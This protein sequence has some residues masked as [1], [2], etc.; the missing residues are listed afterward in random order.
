MKK[1]LLLIIIG[2]LAFEAKRIYDKPLQLHPY[3]YEFTQN[4]PIELESSP[5]ILIV[6]DRMGEKLFEFK[7]Q[8]QQALSVNLTKPIIIE[9]L[10][11]AGEGFHRTLNKIKRIKKL[12]KV[13]IYLGGSEEFHE[14]KYEAKNIDLILK[15]MDHYQNSTLQS[16]LFLN[17]FFSKFIYENVPLFSLTEA[18]KPFEGFKEENIILKQAELEYKLYELEMDDFMREVKKQN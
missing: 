12:P 7:N 14:Q 6:G 2:F 8:M 11:Q 18:I 1:L 4:P 13:I 17:P 9:S 3:P 15:N 5:Q 16:L 10:A